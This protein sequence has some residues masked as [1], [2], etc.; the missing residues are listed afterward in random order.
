MRNV[1]PFG[2]ESIVSYETNYF[3]ASTVHS[4]NERLFRAERLETGLNR[5]YDRIKR[6]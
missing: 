5:P 1:L 2:A 4:G 6:Q 3:T